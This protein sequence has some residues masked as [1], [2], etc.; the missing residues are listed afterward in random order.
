[1][2]RAVRACASCRRVHTACDNIRPCGRCVALGKADECKDVASK[3]RGRPRLNGE[4]AAADEAAT[5]GLNALIGE[6]FMKET[7]PPPSKNKRVKITP[8]QG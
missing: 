4:P 5:A 2:H 1:M 6:V 8:H 3:K 7:I